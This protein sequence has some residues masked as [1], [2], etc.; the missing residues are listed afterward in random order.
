[1]FKDEWSAHLDFTKT[2]ELEGLPGMYSRGFDLFSLKTFSRSLAE[3]GWEKFRGDI[4]YRQTF[5]EIKVP[6]GKNLYVLFGGVDRFLKAWVNG[7][8]I[9]EGTGGRDFAPVL[10]EIPN[11]ENS[12]ENVL[13]V[14]VNNES[15]TEL[16]VGGII[17]PVALIL[18]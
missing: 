3:Q 9:G 18:K 16:G 7:H 11:F 2:G 13:V 14:R 8:S 1:M 10:L 12:Q 4:W 5:P 6:E 17:R 15:P